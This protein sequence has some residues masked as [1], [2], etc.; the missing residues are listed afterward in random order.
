MDFIKHLLEK[1]YF[2]SAYVG[3]EKRDN[4]SGMAKLIHTFNY[5]P[6]DGEYALSMPFEEMILYLK[7][8]P[9]A[10]LVFF[11][12][13]VM[14]YKRNIRFRFYIQNRCVS[15]FFEPK[16]VTVSETE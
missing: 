4:E 2:K 5:K 1:N 10:D 6:R 12:P 8:N 7:A 15:K 14:A 11:G 3:V 9:N 16:E 13:P